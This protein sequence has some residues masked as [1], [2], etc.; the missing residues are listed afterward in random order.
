VQGLYFFYLDPHFTRPA[1]PYHENAADYTSDEVET[2][3][4][5]KLRRLHIKEM[6]PSMLIGFLIRSEDDWVDWRRSVKHVQGKSI[7]HVSDHDPVAHCEANESSF[8]D[9]VEAMSD[10]ENDGDIALE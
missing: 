1:L 10:D 4:T 2:C 7:I 6:D 8:M 9:Q 5:R 3:H